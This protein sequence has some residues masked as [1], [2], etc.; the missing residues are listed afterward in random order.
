[1]T[2]SVMPVTGNLAWTPMPSVDHIDILDRFNGVPTLGVVTG[3]GGSHLFWRVAGYVTTHVSCWIY[4]PLDDQDVAALE[5]GSEEDLL[6]GLVFASPKERYVTVSAAWDYRVIFE[7]EWLLPADLTSDQMYAAFV[8][9][10][11]EAMQMKVDQGLPAS[12]LEILRAASA[13]VREMVTA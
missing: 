3:S 13:A 1:M 4:V 5:H 8:R 10:L 9:F 6:H 11:A 2:R 7:R 12:R